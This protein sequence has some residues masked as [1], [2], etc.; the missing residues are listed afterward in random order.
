M[1]RPTYIGVTG[2]MA[3]QE[4]RAALRCFSGSPTHK[5][6]AGIL[7]S[8]KTLAGKTNRWPGRYPK[9]ERIGEIFQEHPAA[10]NLIHYNTDEPNT[11]SGQ[12]LRLEVAGPYMHGFQL[13]VAWPSIGEIE[14]FHE[15]TDFKQRI[16]LQIGRRAI[17]EV[18]NSPEKLTDMVYHYVGIVE[19][20][21]LDPSGGKGQPFDIEKAGVFLRAIASRGFEINLGIA[22][23]L[24]PDSL[25]LVEPFLEK[26]PQ[27]NIDAEGR[28][29][30]PEND[31]LDVIRMTDYIRSSL[32]MFKEAA[33]P[34]K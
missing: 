6:M 2:F 19:D 9:I 33:R 4:V 27:L 1:L 15:A 8:S 22:G 7:V 23:G 18:E 29:R 10:V 30:D 14:T 24:G 5:L 13:N 16:V 26:F 12:L 11:L 28:L 25:H 21:L 3:P 34:K 17:E 20:I 32:R 31:D